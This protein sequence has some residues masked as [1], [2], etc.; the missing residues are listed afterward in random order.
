MAA[1]GIISSDG[2]T[3]YTKF[4]SRMGESAANFGA[5]N[6][7]NYQPSS[8]A[9]AGMGVP[10]LKKNYTSDN[11]NH[12]K[13][14]PMNRGGSQHMSGTRGQGDFNSYFRS[15][16]AAMFGSHAI[17]MPKIATNHLRA[18]F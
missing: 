17:A 10:V 18:K 9:Y 6:Q 7:N 5:N 11:F 13:P 16:A 14:Y 12:D 3:K 4:N 1:T 2:P 8:N 15:S